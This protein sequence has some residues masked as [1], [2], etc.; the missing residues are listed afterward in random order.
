MYAIRSYYE[1][2][3]VVALTSIRLKLGTQRTYIVDLTMTNLLHVQGIK[4]IVINIQDNTDRV[5]VIKQVYES[6]EKYRSLLE[7]ANDGICLL[8][9]DEIVFSN[10]KLSSML[11]V[12]H[13]D[14]TGVSPLKY[15][16]KYQPDGVLSADRIT[17]VV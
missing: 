2:G 14:L 1:P 4:G 15:A 12:K 7:N 9:I 10:S 11:G 5:E 13:G 8:T 3:K 17:N 16:P 6:E